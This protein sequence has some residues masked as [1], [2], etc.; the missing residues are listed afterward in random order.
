MT[1]FVWQKLRAFY[2]AL[3]LFFVCTFTLIGYTL[4]HLHA[5][6]VSRGVEKTEIYAQNVES[7]LTQSLN[8]IDLVRSNILLLGVG[9]SDLRKLERSLVDALRSTPFLRSISLQD[10]AGRIVASTNPA[11]L[12][13]SVKT[14]EYKP[15]GSWIRETMRVG[16]TW[17]GR[18][19]ADGQPATATA[20]ASASDEAK[21]RSFVPVAVRLNDGDMT[22][23]IALNPDYFTN[24]ATGLL[25]AQQGVVDLLGFDGSLLMSTEPTQKFGLPHDYIASDWLPKGVESGK[26][27]QDDS[28][29]R[30]SLVAL[31]GLDAYPFVVRVSLYRGYVLQDWYRQ[32]K[33]LLGFT[34]PGSLLIGLVAEALHRRK[35]Q[36]ARQQDQ[37]I[38]GVVFDTS[39]DAIVITDS[40]ANIV[41]VNGAFT[42]ETGYSAEEVLGRDPRLLAS[43]QHNNLFYKN[44]WEDLLRDGVWRGELV[45]RRKDGILY[46]LEMTIS[47]VRDA[48]KGVQHFISVSRDITE[49]K[50]TEAA[51]L[52]ASALQ[53][54]IF[55]SVNFS[56]IATDAKGVI[57]I[58]NVGA[59]RMLGYSAAEAL[60]NIT[61]ADISDPLEL[62]ARAEAL[63][64]ELSTPITPGFEA[65]VFK[66]S[67]G[68]EDI[69][70]LTY[71]RKDGSR[72]PAVVSVTAL[73]DAQNAIIGYLLIGTDNT[74]RKQ[75]EEAML[76][77]RKKAADQMTYLAKNDSLTGLPNRV[78]F[79]ERLDHAITS[80]QALGKLVAV[81]LLDLV[82]FKNVNDTL[83]HDAGDQILKQVAQRLLKTMRSVDTVARMSGDEFTIVMTN[84]RNV[85]DVARVAQKILNAFEKPF[86]VAGRELHIGASLGIAIYPLHAVNAKELMNHADIAMYSAKAA[87]D[88]RYQF[89][90]T[91]MTT[92]A[93]DALTLENELRHAL[94]RGEFLL[95][96]QPVVDAGGR[97][98]GA[99]ALLRWQHGQ[100]GLIQPA[101]FI[102]LAE[103]TGLI[104]PIGDWVLR[105]AIAQ[106]KTWKNPNGA[107]LGLG[108]N[109]SPRQF[110]HGSLAET[111]QKVLAE[112]GLNPSALHIEITEGVIMQEEQHTQELFDQLS[113]L[114]ISFVIDDFGTG[115]SNLGY[116]KR[117]PID[118]LK[119]DQSFIRDITTDP[120]DAAIVKAI[121]VMAHGLGIK[122]IAEGVETREQKEFLLAQG[123]DFMQG[124][125]FSRPLAPEA[126]AALLEAGKPLGHGSD[127]DNFQF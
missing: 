112:T 113:H 90:Q 62:I 114:G 12:G 2:G 45:N 102:A 14:Q 110:N 93:V 78:L 54:A 60:N 25:E 98:V 66:A 92:Q 42:R 64:V 43:G 32:L 57:Q 121:I 73:R 109:V 53:D 106:A 80:A 99:E 37:L 126:F 17:F 76:T 58:F 16:Q 15:T 65:L 9:G 29:A 13:V 105:E 85:D 52:K 124:Y 35:L 96:Y 89:Y 39:S 49:R 87:G 74:E 77:E 3:A 18:D 8:T 97:I 103:T 33:M 67:R 83:G 72:F 40:Q 117:F 59:E 41:S 95:H 11:N 24:H 21:A 10:A 82:R 119:I 84:I 120:N 101:R 108:V 61:P 22:L 107:L 23:L 26:S 1:Q 111:V 81:V 4:W 88:N 5:Q 30:G 94:K 46:D 79:Q 91:E 36:F 127:S 100:R 38:S 63:S 123:C 27:K 115:Y 70:E 31:R 86:Y 20:T 118:S 71:V 6:A 7:L 28:D 56:S 55:N 68:M 34:I 47:V 122:T 44:M 48:E 125:Y 75:D 50:Q 104:L 19:F 51:L 116:L 69:Y